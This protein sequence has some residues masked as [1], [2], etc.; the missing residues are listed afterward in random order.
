MFSKE[1]RRRYG[2]D[3]LLVRV[4][5]N[6]RHTTVKKKGVKPLFKNAGA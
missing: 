6:K 3:Q 4:R 1:K 5:K 2:L